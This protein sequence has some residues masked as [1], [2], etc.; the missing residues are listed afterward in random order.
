MKKIMQYSVLI[1]LSGCIVFFS[2]KKE[3]ETPIVIQ[4]IVIQPPH[5]I[6]ARII[7]YGTGL[8]LADAI[9]DVVAVT[10]ATLP[11]SMIFKPTDINGECSFLG[12]GVAFREFSKTG[13]GNTTI[14]PGLGRWYQFSPI[15]LFPTTPPF[16]YFSGSNLYWCDSFLV[17]LFPKK[18]ITIRL[19]DSLRLN[20]C[21]DDCDVIFGMNGL[22]SEQGID[23]TVYNTFANRITLRPNI[24][25]TFQYPVFSNAQN[26]FNV[27]QYEREYG[28]IIRSF[29]TD[30]VFIANNSNH[31]LNIAF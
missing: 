26:S 22:F 5:A 15:L 24:D 18:Y 25:T 20:T 12:N 19:V 28:F 6:K 8:P 1:I 14:Y 10:S 30:T 21:Q 23:H 7:E 13:Y 27:S 11:G 2:C 31:I 17:K 9:V 3:S 4:P 29:F 16:G